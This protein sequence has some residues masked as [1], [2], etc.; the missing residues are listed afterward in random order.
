MIN[1]QLSIVST[2]IIPTFIIPTLI[3]K[4]WTL[5]QISCKTTILFLKVF[6]KWNIFLLSEKNYHQ[7]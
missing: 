2:I 7:I 6:L 4:H 5:L 3:T 1:D